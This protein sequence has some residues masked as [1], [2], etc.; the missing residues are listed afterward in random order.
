MISR[1]PRRTLSG[2]TV[3]PSRPARTDS[4]VSPVAFAS[5]SAVERLESRT[6]MAADVVISEFMAENDSTLAD[7]DGAFSDWIELHNRGDD[8]QNLDGWFLTDSSAELTQWRLPAV[9]L[10]PGEYLTVFASNKDITTGTELHTNF[11]LAQGGEYL[12]LVRPDGVTV[13]HGY[14]PSYPNQSADVSYGLSEEG[15]AASTAVQPFTEP[16]PGAPNIPNA[17]APVFSV[18]S[19]TFTGS[20][21]L[22]LS[23]PPGA[24][25]GSEIR[26]TTNRTLPTST[27]T[28]YTGP[29]TISNSTVVR[30]LVTAPGRTPSPVVSRNYVALD[31][32]V[33]SFNSNLPVVIMDSFGGGFNDTTLTPVSAYFIDTA[34]SDGRAEMLDAPDFAGRGGMRLRG[35]S[36]QGFPQQ[37]Y[38]FETWDE[39]NGDKSVSILGMPAESDWILY[40]P[41][42]EKSLMQNSLAYEWANRM[43]QYAVR[44]R[45][46]ELFVNTASG[47][48]IDYAGDYRGVYI[49]MEK[50]KVDDDRVDIAKLDPGDNAEPDVTGGYIWKHDKD[51]AGERLF[52]AGGYSWNFHEPSQDEIT[53]Q[54]EDYLR[55]YLDEFTSVIN[56]PSFADPVNGYARYID[57]DSWIDHHIMVE[58]TKNIDGFRISTYY[59]K[60]R[61]GKIKMGPVWD[62]NLSLG[63]ADYNNG[64]SPTGWYNDL[65]SDNDYRYFR[66]LFQDPAFRQ[67]YQ[68]RWQELR[69]D[70]LSTP[71]L[72]ADVDELTSLLSDNNGNY[73]VGN[74][75]T[76]VSNNPVVRHYKKWAHLANDT[77][78]NYYVDPSWI[79]HVNWMKNWL[80]QRLAWWD[81]Q[82]L[83]APTI[84]PAGGQVTA[85]QTVTI[86]ST[87][88]QSFV[89]T[90]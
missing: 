13:Q 80:Q 59:H 57:V 63:N 71:R 19:R 46:V 84:T 72:M 9:T 51:D 90:P 22:A 67:R 11:A 45:Y 77:W 5:P 89:D 1:R 2:R 41:Y 48:R 78:P 37:P 4:V 61:N 10:F 56:G 30:A 36:S 38:A 53:P 29:I 52:D 64:G 35:Q 88:G 73:P 23:L 20:I 66:R 16:S 12:A 31:A 60:D 3:R 18:D 62:Y 32:S 7:R 47:G 34:A 28:L 75:P 82:Y 39:N 43:G 26:Y 55:G 14:V 74:S 49:F 33:Q 81:S 50:I 65:L 21:S 8:F 70:V 17:P 69:R 68:D 42:S 87:G 44:T 6:L 86:T 85:P 25:A 40:A 58:L 54:Q 83:A 15:N 79:N 27:S 24:P 76:Q